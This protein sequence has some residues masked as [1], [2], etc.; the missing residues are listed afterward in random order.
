MIEYCE[1][2]CE[3]RRVIALLYFDENFN[4]NDC[5]K[6]CDNCKKDLQKEEPNVTEEAVIILPFLKKLSF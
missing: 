3:C 6:M 5:N 1:D 2:V 4:R